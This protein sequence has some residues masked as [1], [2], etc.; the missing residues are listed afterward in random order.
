LA[1][2]QAKNLMADSGVI[3]ITLTRF[4]RHMDRKPPSYTHK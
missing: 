1:A 4:P 2:S 3:F